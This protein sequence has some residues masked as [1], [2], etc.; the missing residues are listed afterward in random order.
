MSNFLK[1]LEQK[2]Y[3]RVT[4]KYTCYQL[5]ISCPL[6]FFG[7]V[8]EVLQVELYEKVIFTVIIS[9]NSL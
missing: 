2:R 9:N 6:D 4:S 3:M 5:D 8:L 7:K 1:N